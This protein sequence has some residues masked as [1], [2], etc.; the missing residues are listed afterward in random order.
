[1]ETI[2]T[3]ESLDVSVEDWD[4]WVVF[5]IETK[6]SDETKKE[7]ETH[8]NGKTEI[9]SFER[10][11]KFLEIRHRILEANEATDISEQKKV[12]IA[13][14]NT[15]NSRKRDECE[16]CKEKHYIFFCPMFDGWSIYERIKFIRDN[17]RCIKCLNKHDGQCRSK[18]NCKN[19]NSNN[20]NTKLCENTQI[21]T[22]NQMLMALLKLE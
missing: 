13:N 17:K 22:R 15:Q 3:I 20:H 18:Y 16:I 10:L 6:M 9:P 5:H 4:P 1:M 8:L 2:Q 21:A 11:M 19:C 7:W 12:K 14:I